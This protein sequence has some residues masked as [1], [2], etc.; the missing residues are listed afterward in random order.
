MVRGGT[1]TASSESKKDSSRDKQVSDERTTTD[2]QSADSL[3]LHADSV[4]E[5]APQE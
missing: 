3:L 2:I 4:I 5:T 1:R